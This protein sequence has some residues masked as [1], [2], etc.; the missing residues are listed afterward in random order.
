MY[1]LSRPGKL[2]NQPRICIHVQRCLWSL[3]LEHREISIEWPNCACVLGPTPVTGTTC[4]VLGV[5]PREQ[6]NHDQLNV[7]LP[8]FVAASNN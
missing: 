8:Q 3:R 7:L 1:G 2:L 5:W 4:S 6:A